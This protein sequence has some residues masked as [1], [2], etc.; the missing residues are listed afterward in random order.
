MSHNTVHTTASKIM[1][2][3]FVVVIIITAI[4]FNS[5]KPRVMILHSYQKDYAWTR[6]INVGF[7]RV[8][9][10]WVGYSVTWHYMD[11]KKHNDKDWL[12]RAGIIARRAID[13][14]D[15]QVLI[16]VDDFAQSLAAKYYVNKPGIQIVFAGV[17]GSVEPYGYIGADNVTGIFEHKQLKPVKETVLALEARKRTLAGMENGDKGA[18]KLLYL[19]DPS[20]S[21]KRGKPFIDNYNWEPVHYSGAVIADNYSHWKQLVLGKGK[22]VDYILISNYRK[23]PRSDTDERFMDPKEV[24]TWTEAHSMVPV[25]G[26]NVFNVE[27]GAMLSVG[28]SPYEQGEV[29]AKL[30][31]KLIKEEIKAQE[32]PFQKNKMYIIAMNESLLNK[33]DLSL[34]SIYEA[35]GRATENF[36][37]RKVSGDK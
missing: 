22:E 36:I 33:R 27:D 6:D 11:T 29:A 21:I 30:A 3:L 9:K 5:Q 19:M 12:T 2:L 14:T 17:N 32:I 31:E 23:L 1:S 13:K 35:F 37:E 20:A 24:M 7:E 16:A 15:P 18:P 8:L 4:I 28:V 10:T 25:I 26:I 34:P